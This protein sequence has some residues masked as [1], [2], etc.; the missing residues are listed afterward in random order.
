[1]EFLAGYT[2]V[3]IAVALAAAIAAAFIRGLAGFGMAILLVPILALAMSPLEAVLATNVVAVLIGL[4][5][6]KRITKEAEKS[7]WTISLLVVIAT[8]PGLYLLS[9]TAA[10]LARVLIA[11]IALSAFFAMLLPKRPAHRPGA[12]QTGLVG[13]ISGLLTGFAGMPGP[14]VV[15]YYLGRDIP[16]E[17]A[18]PSM[19][20]IFT[21]AAVAGLGSGAAIGVMSWDL[22][23][24]GALLFPAVLLGN[25]LGARAFGRVSDTTWRFFV[26]TVLAVTAAASLARLLG[27]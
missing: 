10:P 15:P 23:I 19:L 8:F 4:S 16:K 18:K 1:V 12:V 9:V 11:L 27:G 14:P 20:L 17:I 13:I 25:Y 2:A 22:L 26:M 7:A 6:L 3:Q 5:E 24:L 21:F